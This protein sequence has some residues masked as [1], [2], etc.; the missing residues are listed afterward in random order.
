MKTWK[1]AAR[2]LMRAKS[3]TIINVAGLALSLGCCIM[4]VRYLHREYT[5]D[6]HCVDREHVVVPLRDVDGNVIP[7]DMNGN[8]NNPDTVYIAGSQV[9]ERCRFILNQDNNVQQGDRRFRVNVLVTDS[10]FFRLFRYPVRAGKAALE[11]PTD[12]VLTEECARRFFGQENPVGRAL[13]YSGR[14]V[15]VRGVI[16][17]PACKTTFRFDMVVAYG[18]NKDG[19]KR[20]PGELIHVLPSVDLAAINHHA[21]VY[22][23]E[24]TPE[25]WYDMGDRRVRYHFL[26]L[27]EFYFDQVSAYEGTRL[28]RQQGNLRTLHLLMGVVALLLLV[29]MLNFVNIY[30]VLLMKRSKEYGIKKVFG[31]QRLPLFLQIYAE[32]FLL[33][34]GALVLAWTLVEVGQPVLSRQ[35]GDT[36]GY[37]AFDAWLSLGFLFLFP[38]LTSVYPY[39]RYNYRPPLLSLRTIG[40]TRQSVAVRMGFLFLQY[41]VTLLLVM[42]SVYFVRQL[43]LWLNTSPGFRT[44]GIVYADFD[45]EQPSYD[46]AARKEEQAESARRQE[47]VHRIEACPY[48]DKKLRM[49]DDVL[50]PGYLSTLYND[51]GEQASMTVLF[52]PPGFFDIFDIPV[53]EGSVESEGPGY[54][55]VLNRRAMEVF[56]YTHREEAFVRS[57][58]AMWISVTEN[59]QIE[60]GGKQLMPVSAVVENYCAGHLSRGVQPIVFMVNNDSGGGL[61]AFAVSPQHERDLKDYLR[62]TAEEVYHTDEFSYTRL[63]DRVAAIYA[64]D[65]RVAYVSTVFALIAILVSC[66]GL[67]G[68]S[69]FD[70]RQRYREIAIRKVNGAKQR[71]LYRLLF[72]KYA[73]V[74]GAAFVVSV[75]V[76]VYI[77]RRY[78]ADYVVKAPLQVWVFAVALLVVVLL[79]WGTLW[80]QIRR[81]ASANPVD[82]LKRE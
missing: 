70:I 50:D 33:C 54:R 15:T 43:H 30:M 24:K 29:G 26:T 81:A 17:Q 69:L 55:M 56:G 7:T 45:Y 38:L 52:V 37:T 63:S 60:E 16:G 3:Y 65:R 51:R 59:G 1:Y 58:T 11:A 68:V 8:W 36:I 76:A 78:T 80:W 79:S 18:L 12:V 53:L 10:V 48:V 57:E 22:R 2:H 77:V 72:R 44:E 82:A 27:D 20:M 9:L 62:Q 35:V 61:W 6:T 64:D 31:L 13:N 14:E 5:V 25:G 46:S 73:A 74:L 34:A 42:L 32:N 19:W 66:L 71:D 39:L 23:E 21:H 41:L 49:Y 75:P 28:M 40:T 67:L 4:L 47:V